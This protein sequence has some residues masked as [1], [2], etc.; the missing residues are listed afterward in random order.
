M[1]AAGVQKAK[2][3]FNHIKKAGNKGSFI[4]TYQDT[5][6]KKDGKS[7]NPSP[8]QLLKLFKT[9]FITG[10]NTQITDSDS[11]V[12]GAIART[13][14]QAIYTERGSIKT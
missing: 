10:I 6:Y 9:D 11:L 3:G 7:V 4:S 5:G 14:R 1:A 13:K 12:A 2:A 8:P